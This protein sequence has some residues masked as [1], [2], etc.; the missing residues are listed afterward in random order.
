MS[1]E[2]L[3]RI[4]RLLETSSQKVDT[5]VGAIEKNSEA[6]EK[7]RE[8]IEKNREAIEINRQGIERNSEAIERN[9]LGIERNSEDLAFIIKQIDSNHKEQQRHVE[10]L[11]EAFRSEIRV[12]VEGIGHNTA[13]LDNHESRLNLLETGS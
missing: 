4:E 9:R 12:L 11:L 1:E 7:N 10:M 3:E 2:R 13:R 8:A 6:I 5:N